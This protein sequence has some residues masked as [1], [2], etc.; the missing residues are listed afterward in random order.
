MSSPVHK[1]GEYQL[2]GDGQVS[3]HARLTWIPRVFT[4]MF[5]PVDHCRCWYGGPLRRLIGVRHENMPALPVSDW[6]VRRP[7]LASSP[8]H[9]TPNLWATCN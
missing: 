8:H 7:S 6:S 1:G 2:A 3:T 4:P 5:L 9:T